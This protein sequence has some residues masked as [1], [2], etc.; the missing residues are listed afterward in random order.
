MM[1]SLRVCVCAVVT[2]A[3]LFLSCETVDKVM[4]VVT[5]FLISDYQE[6]QMGENF[7]SQIVA[8]TV[9]YR[10]YTKNAQV[11]SYVRGIGAG[12]VSHQTDRP[13]VP[14]TLEYQ[15]DVIDN[16]TVVNA[17]A[18]PGGH[19]FVY[20][21]LLLNA[22]NEAEVAAVISHEVGHITNRHGAKKLVE[23]YGI[24]FCMDL[25]FGDSTALRSAMDLATGMLFLKFSRENEYE[26]D[27]SG[28]AYMMESGYNPNG[29]VTFFQSLIDSAGTPVGFEVFS[30]HPDTEDR[31]AAVR[32][33]IQATSSA[34]TTQAALY[35]SRFTPIKTILQND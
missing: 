12:V 24:D 33:Q 21:G 8:D 10:L 6:S 29:M 26:A 31:I 28:L 2:T 5:P 13:E 15:F 32:R 30:T 27:S 22:T 14:D 11:V 4:D 19:V 3:P 16:D 18:I 25:I 17:F 23:S 35:E 7:Y 34:D 1:K 9:S 20:T